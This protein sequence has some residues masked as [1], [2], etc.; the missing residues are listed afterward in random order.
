MSRAAGQ[1]FGEIIADG[2]DISRARAGEI[3]CPLMML[4]GE[5]DFLATPAMVSDFA[6]AVPG[7]RFVEVEGV[8][9][10][11]HETKPEWFLETLLTWLNDH[12]E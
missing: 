10:A 11:I 8:G 6:S 7:A 5:K 2:G 3:A 12:R 9:H 1:A 4:A